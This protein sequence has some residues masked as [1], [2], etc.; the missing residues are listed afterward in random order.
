MRK[1]DFDRLREFIYR[2]TGILFEPQKQYYVERRVEQHM[3]SRGYSSFNEYFSALRFGRGELWQE[4]LNSLTVNETYFFREYD[5]LKCF[6]E[7][8]LPLWVGNGAGRAGIKIWSAGCSTGE[9]A[10]TL[11]IIMEE[12]AQGYP[13]EIH[14]TDINTEVLARA[15]EGVYNDYA[16]RQVP[17]VY[18]TRYFTRVNGG[19]A[20]SPLLKRRVKFYQVN[21]MDDAR[22]RQMKGFH[23]IFC[24][25]VLIYFDDASRR[26]VALHFYQALEP[27]GY[28]FL[29]HSESMSRITTVFKPV[30][31]KNA[32]IYQKAG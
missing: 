25:N 12:M 22:M 18:F 16:V 15:Q 26:R 5:Q 14:A 2:Q 3:A 20:V 9:E 23:A 8:V 13:W 30:R 7:E 17:D 4:L 1:A 31:F 6:A 32:I 29:G 24:R 28:I 21:L 11:A 19:Y 27:N 10:Y